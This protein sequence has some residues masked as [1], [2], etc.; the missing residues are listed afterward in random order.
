MNRKVRRSIDFIHAPVI[1]LAK[2]QA[3]WIKGGFSLGLTGQRLRRICSV[4]VIHVVKQGSE[5]NVAGGGRF[6][7]SPTQAG[8]IGH[9]IIAVGRDGIP[10]AAPNKQLCFAPDHDVV[11][12]LFA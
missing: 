7:R 11:N 8:G 3:P 10:G 6:S 12:F 5:I 2:C 4:R 9:V 1:G